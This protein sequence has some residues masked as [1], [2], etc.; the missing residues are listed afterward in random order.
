MRQ[1]LNFLG[2]VLTLSLLCSCSKDHQPEEQNQIAVAIAEDPSTLDPRLARSLASATYLK[3]LYEGLTRSNAKGEPELALASS[4]DISSDGMRYVFTLRKSRWSDGTPLTA[5][6]FEESWKSMLSPGFPAPNAYQLFHIKN[7]Q[8]IKEGR[9]PLDQAGIQAV[10]SNTLVVE[11]ERPCPYFTQLLSCHFYLPVSKEMRNDQPNRGSQQLA[12]GNGPFLGK[13]WKPRNE[14]ILEK[15]PS[16]WDS[17]SVKIQKVVFQV[18][19]EN[20]A[21][22][23]FLGGKLDWAGSPLSTLPQDAVASLKAQGLLKISPGAGTQWFRFNTQAIPFNNEKMR[24]AFSYALN[25]QEIADHV[26]QG[27]QLPAIGIIPP[28]MGI[29]DQRYF[30]DNDSVLAKRLFEEAAAEL[31]AENSPQQVVLRY[32]ATDRNHKIAQAVQQ[33][34]NALFGELVQLQSGEMHLFLD[35]VR[36]GEYQIA[37]GSWFA[38]IRD[39]IN[40]LEIFKTKT[41]ATNQTF[42]E[43]PDYQ[44][45]LDRSA[46]EL[47]ATKRMALLAEAEQLLMSAMPV[48]P[49]LHSS[50]NYLVASK[51]SGV[52][53]SE[54][55]YL[56]FKNASTIDT[57]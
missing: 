2:W 4:I 10:S 44:A 45:L 29:E 20:T 41:R 8:A 35:S 18:L 49:L 12:V 5:Q 39:P 13:S 25:R 55:G 33:Q 9:L 30:K 42:W 15:N 53:F 51:I 19:D 43:S 14:F 54:L 27:G 21:L 7:A 48:A 22:Q 24:K 57:P 26:T 1:S 52:Y 3:M 6:D 38:D 32:A 34:W 40:F 17:A 47:D 56:D 16:Y 36:N 31:K 28:G 37:L 11:L 50:Y 23:L 46:N